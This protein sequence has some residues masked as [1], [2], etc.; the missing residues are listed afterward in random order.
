M[1]AISRNSR[2]AWALCGIISLS[3]LQYGLGRV[4]NNDSLESIY[5]FAIL[6]ASDD[7]IHASL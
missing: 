2:L 4:K 5:R 1:G 3:M 7:V 6:D